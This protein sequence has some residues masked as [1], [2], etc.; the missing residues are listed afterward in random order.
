MQTSACSG[1]PVSG[2]CTGFVTNLPVILINNLI[3]LSLIIRP[4]EIQCCVSGDVPSGSCD[5]SCGTNS[6]SSYS[7]S[8]NGVN[9]I[10]AFEGF[11]STC[12]QVMRYNAVYIVLCIV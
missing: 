5:Y 11:S 6:A 7:T 12:Y 1:T 4:S 2:Y 8:S 10:T 3:S 9:L